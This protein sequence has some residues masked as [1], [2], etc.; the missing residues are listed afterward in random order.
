M[1]K[2]ALAKE[3]LVKQKN[4]ITNTLLSQRLTEDKEDKT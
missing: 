4:P 2:S 3:K 1:A